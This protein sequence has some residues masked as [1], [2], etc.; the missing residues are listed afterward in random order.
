MMNPPRVLC[1]DDNADFLACLSQRL[2]HFGLEVVTACHGV[3]ALMKLTEHKGKFDAIL[4]D[5]EMVE[6]GGLDLVRFVREMGFVGRII[7]M[8]GNLS[9]EDFREYQPYSVSGF[10]GKPFDTNL[11]IEMLGSSIAFTGPDYYVL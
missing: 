4:T 8:S 11:L 2:K 7:V 3:D 10:F 6:I 9:V 1:V 5:N